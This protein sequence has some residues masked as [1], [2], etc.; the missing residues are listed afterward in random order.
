MYGHGREQGTRRVWGATPEFDA[1]QAAAL[2][3]IEV[4]WAEYAALECEQCSRTLTPDEVA[5]C[6][7]HGAA[8]YRNCERCATSQF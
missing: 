2:A 5:A 6:E 4:Q 3:R 7:V 8:Y 1:L